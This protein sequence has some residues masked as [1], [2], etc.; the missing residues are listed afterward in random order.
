MEEGQINLEKFYKETQSCLN[1]IAKNMDCPDRQDWAYKALRAV[2]HSVRDRLEVND[3]H[4]LSAQLPVLIR[5]FYFEGY[6]PAG[7]P[8]EMTPTQFLE[9]IRE[10]MGTTVEVT[11]VVALRAVLR[12]LYDRTS[13]RDVEEVRRRM[14]EDLK[15]LW[16]AMIPKM[17]QFK[18]T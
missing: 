11:P 3:V 4:Y 16:A 12:G 5:G 1:D 14:P 6:V 18:T 9:K 15:Q 13:P 2:L 10:R 8:K 17:E 7:K